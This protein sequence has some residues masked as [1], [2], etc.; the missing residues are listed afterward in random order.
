M[1]TGFSFHEITF[2]L[3]FRFCI[4]VE[5]PLIVAG[6]KIE[7]QIIFILSRAI[8]KRSFVA[9]S[10]LFV[11]VSGDFQNPSCTQLATS[12]LLCDNLVDRGAFNKQKFFGLSSNRQMPIV[13]QFSVN[14][15][16]DGGRFEYWVCLSLSLH[17]QSSF[18][19]P[20]DLQQL[21]EVIFP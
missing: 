12:E 2:L 1:R 18:T 3:L 11:L 20:D 14:L 5:H 19:T 9:Y 13:S 16:D 15:F 7:T 6:N 17:T 10:L 8:K 4:G 21:T